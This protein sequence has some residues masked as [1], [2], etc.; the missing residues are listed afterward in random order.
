MTDRNPENP[1]PEHNPSLRLRIRMGRLAREHRAAQA[2]P[3]HEPDELFEA[4]ETGPGPQGPEG[5]G[6]TP[7]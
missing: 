5:P 3:A 1:E 2:D 4:L 6:H 7:D